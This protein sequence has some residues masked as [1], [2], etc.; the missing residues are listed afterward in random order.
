MLEEAPVG[1]DKRAV[2]FNCQGYKGGVV[3]REV[4]LAA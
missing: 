3:K 4:K 1:G 2:Q